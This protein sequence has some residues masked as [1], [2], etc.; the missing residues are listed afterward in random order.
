MM[1]AIAMPARGAAV[2]AAPFP[3]SVVEDAPPSSAEPVGVVV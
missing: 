3:P 1:A 2:A